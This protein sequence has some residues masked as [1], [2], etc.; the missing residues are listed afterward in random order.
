MCIRGKEQWLAAVVGVI[1]VQFFQQISQTIPPNLT[2]G[3]W[4]VVKGCQGDLPMWVT[5]SEDPL[6]ANGR[7]ADGLKKLNCAVKHSKTQVNTQAGIAVRYCAIK[8]ITAPP[9]FQTPK[10]HSSNPSL[11]DAGGRGGGRCPLFGVSSMPFV[12]WMTDACSFPFEA[13]LYKCTM[14]PN[15]VMN[16]WMA[17]M[18]Q[19]EITRYAACTAVCQYLEIVCSIAKRG[20]HNQTQWQQLGPFLASTPALTVR[21]WCSSKLA[22]PPNQL[23]SPP[24]SAPPALCG[25]VERPAARVS[26]HGTVHVLQR[27]AVVVLH[28]HVVVGLHQKLVV[29]TSK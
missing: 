14:G 9:H 17:S 29:D 20:G 11:S 22:N 27:R 18:K 15:G 13:K 4:G 1:E 5:S 10:S 24:I 12:P 21:C 25:S 3:L 6:M 28:R 16:T 19:G 8:S 7:F 26:P 23:M 2:T